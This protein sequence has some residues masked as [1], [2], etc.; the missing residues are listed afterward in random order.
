MTDNLSTCPKCGVKETCYITPVNE[1]I[2]PPQNL[3]VVT[4]TLINNF[5]D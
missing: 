1:L 4:T 5:L 2:Y 3:D